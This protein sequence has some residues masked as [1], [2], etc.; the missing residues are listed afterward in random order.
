MTEKSSTNEPSINTNR[1]L[2]KGVLFVITQSE[3]GGAQRFLHTLITR[4]DKSRYE[5]LVAAGPLYTGRR[6]QKSELRSYDLVDRLETEGLK[7]ARLRPLHREIKPFSVLR[8]TFELKK[9]IKEFHPNTLFLLSSKAGF[10]GSLAT[11]FPTK[12][13]TKVIYRI[14]GWSFND[15]WPEWK[16]RFWIILEKISAKWKDVIIVNNEHDLEQ[17]KN[18]NIRPKEKIA[19]IHNGIDVY[20]TEFL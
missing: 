5:M 15:P 2:K 17:A 19:L 1:N 9:I 13:K 20:K 8:A 11:V 7:T 3:F 6:T 14:G 18:L 12:L 10:V 4:L 16:K